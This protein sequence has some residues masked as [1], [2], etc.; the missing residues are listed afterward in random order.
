MRKRNA[1]MRKRRKYTCEQ[2]KKMYLQGRH[3][4]RKEVMSVIM[5]MEP[6]PH[7]I[8]RNRGNFLF[9]RGRWGLSH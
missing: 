9:M 4:V 6:S 2:K 5:E 8:M 7:M 1:L 3:F